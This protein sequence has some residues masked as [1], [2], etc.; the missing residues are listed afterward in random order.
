MRIF[1]L[2]KFS[3]LDYPGKVSSIIFL[4]GCNMNCSYCYNS[5]LI[6]MGESNYSEEEILDFLNSRVGKID[7]V[8]ITGG[9][10]TLNNDLI[11]FIKK[12]KKM[13]LLVKLDTNGS[14]PEMI[15]ELLDNKLIDYVAMDVKTSLNKYNSVTNVNVDI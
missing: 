3:L 15:K 8:V 13:G 11:E 1:G 7:G 5:D 14:N 4:S 9:E 6:R 10:P 12:I 2:D